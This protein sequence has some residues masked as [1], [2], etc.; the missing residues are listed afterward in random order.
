MITN[1]LMNKTWFIQLLLVFGIFFLRSLLLAGAPTLWISFSKWANNHRIYGEHANRKTLLADFF[2]GVQVLFMD[3]AA[4]VFLFQVGLF[5]FNFEAST[6]QFWVTF[7][8]FFAWLEIYFYY[9]H[10]LLHHPKLFWIHRHHHKDRATNP[11]TSLSFSVSE[12]IVLHIGSI[13]LPALLSFFIPFSPQAYAFYFFVNYLLNVY[14]HLNTEI[15]PANYVHNFVGKILNTTSYHALHHIRYKGHFGL[16]TPILDK[17]HHTQ[18]ADYEKF[19]EEVVATSAQ[20]TE[21]SA[22]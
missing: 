10:R 15:M 7:F 19:H 4:I 14:G 2:T 8:L 9:S 11:W 5:K 20:R 17:L 18:F 12:R 1:L 6:T 16:F 22:T 13:Y 3:A 21:Q